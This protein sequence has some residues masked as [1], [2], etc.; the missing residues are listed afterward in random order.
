M[1][2]QGG[3]ASEL[4]I[5][6][7]AVGFG[8]APWSRA[9]RWCIR[10]AAFYSTGQAVINHGPV[11][12]SS[13]AEGGWTRMNTDKKPINAEN[14]EARKEFEQTPQLANEQPRNKATKTDWESV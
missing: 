11:L 4:L 14:A 12:R 10:V 6:N 13:T 1:N 2:G 8:L 3:F 5:P 7:S 9:V